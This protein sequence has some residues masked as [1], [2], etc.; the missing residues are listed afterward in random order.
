MAGST[1]NPQE[2]TLS[3]EARQHIEQLM[4]Q[5]KAHPDSPVPL[6]QLAQGYAQIWAKN[7]SADLF[8]RVARC[9]ERAIDMDGVTY[10]SQ[11]RQLLDFVMRQARSQ[12]LQ[13]A[14]KA[15]QSLAERLQAKQLG[16]TASGAAS[17]PVPAPPPA[18][19]P[20]APKAPQVPK[21][22]PAATP[23]PAGPGGLGP[24]PFAPRPD[25]PPAP[26]GPQASAAVASKFQGVGPLQASAATGA[27]AFAETMISHEGEG[28]ATDEEVLQQGEDSE[29]A[30]REAQSLAIANTQMIRQIDDM[31]AED[32][33]NEV[34]ELY[35]GI[36]DRR[37]KRHIIDRFAEK[38]RD[39]EVGPLLAIGAM[40]GNEQIF[41]HMMRTLL[42]T[43]RALVC[44][45][46]DLEQLSPDLRRVG[47]VVLS[48]LG[49]RSALPKLKRGLEVDDPLVRCVALHGIARAGEAAL[50][51][52]SVLV[53]TARGDPDPNV[54]LTAAKAMKSMDLEE[55]YDALE[56]TAVEAKLDPVVLNVLQEMRIKYDPDGSRLARR[57]ADFRKKA[58]KSKSITSQKIE[59]AEKLLEAQ[60]QTMQRMK[61]EASQDIDVQD[62]V[63][64]K[65]KLVKQIVVAAVIGIAAVLLALKTWPT[66]YHLWQAAM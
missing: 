28:G 1:S 61:E 52:I 58:D 45:Q 41:R 48:E 51:Y 19:A 8:E 55:A 38:I 29:E 49:L 50:D 31:L 59:D 24:S 21:P 42:R 54:R 37:L 57:V 53:D 30:R 63:Q 35:S 12:G 2:F 56:T 47:V 10:A 64:K 20:A 16:A 17:A 44:Q 13:D 60:R 14:G 23:S 7:S 36:E 25:A 62:A 26:H 40:E 11:I 65:K 9:V 43:D 66:I 33:V 32:Q 22:A 18:P 39:Y 46:I 34:L 5:V 15:I 4:Q 27:T 6:L 3:S